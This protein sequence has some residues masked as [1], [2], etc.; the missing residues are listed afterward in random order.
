M[1]GSAKQYRNSTGLELFDS[2]C[3]QKILLEVWGSHC[4]GNLVNSVQLSAIVNMDGTF[5]I[6]RTHSHLVVEH[7]IAIIEDALNLSS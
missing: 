1:G 5:S 4:K 6:R 2:L 3:L 7:G